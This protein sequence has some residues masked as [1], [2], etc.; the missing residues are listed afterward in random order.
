MSLPLTFP[1][2]EL[3]DVPERLGKGAQPCA[4]E[5]AGEAFVNSSPGLPQGLGIF[6][7]NNPFKLQCLPVRSSRFLRITALEPHKKVV[8]PFCR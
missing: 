2:P 1:L 7:Y 6:R 8:I 3:G 4:Q 5:G